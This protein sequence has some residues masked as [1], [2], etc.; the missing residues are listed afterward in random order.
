MAGDDPRAVVPLC[1]AEHHREFDEGRLDLASY[2]E[3]HWRESIAW[4]V[5]AVGLFAALRRITGPKT[6][7]EIAEKALVA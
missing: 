5:E 7:A 1:R 4:A 2:L 3:P 6:L